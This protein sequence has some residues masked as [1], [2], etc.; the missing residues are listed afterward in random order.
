MASFIASVHKLLLE[1]RVLLNDRVCGR[2]GLA[3]RYSWADV[4]RD[5]EGFPEMELA[6]P[7]RSEYDEHGLCFARADDYDDDDGLR[8]MEARGSSEFDCFFGLFFEARR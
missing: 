6:F 7:N 4:V 5:P 3:H 8:A 1:V 2:Y